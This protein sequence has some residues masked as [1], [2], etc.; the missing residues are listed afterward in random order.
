[1]RDRSNHRIRI[2]LR[3]PTCVAVGLDPAGLSRLKRGLGCA[4]GGRVL[5]RRTP[6][7]DGAWAVAARASVV[8]AVFDPFA[9]PPLT[10]S[11]AFGAAHPTVGMVAY[12]RLSPDRALEL[13]AVLRGGVQAFVARDV[14]DTPLGFAHHLVRQASRRPLLLLRPVKPRPSRM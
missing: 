3:L 1:M 11:A 8:L 13:M 12:A 14:D 10:G 6:D 7:W 5:V 4:F 9:D 2:R